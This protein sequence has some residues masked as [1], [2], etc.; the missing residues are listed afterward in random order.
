[1]KKIK[2]IVLDTSPIIQIG[3]KTLFKNSSKFELIECYET[4]YDF[5]EYIKSNNVDIIITELELADGSAYDIIKSIRLIKKEI[6]VLV[7]TSKS[8]SLH[9]IDILK[10]GA[11]G[12]LSKNSKKR[13]IKEALEKIAHQKFNFIE[14][15][16]FTRLKNNFSQDYNKIKID[17]LSKREIQVLKLFIKGEKNVKISDK[18]NINQKTVNTYQGRIMKKLGVDSK[19]DLFM[20]ARSH[21]K[22]LY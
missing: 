20:M 10:S 1:M 5:K 7:F 3:F 12:Y 13:V 9:A 14:T 18:L 22:Q 6:P 16:S 17:S 2:I 15:N 4:L 11:I 8:Q 19:V 21:I